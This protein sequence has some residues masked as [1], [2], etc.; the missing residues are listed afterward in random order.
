MTDVVRGYPKFKSTPQRCYFK[1][2]TV[3]DTTT[4]Q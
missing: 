4:Q 1:E 3:A 2:N